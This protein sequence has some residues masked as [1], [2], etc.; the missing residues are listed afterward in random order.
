MIKKVLT[1]VFSLVVIA[2]L[3]VL[4][5]CSSSTSS[6]EQILRTNIA[7]EPAQIDPNRA[8]WSTE[9]TVIMQVFEG[10]LGFNQ[11]LSLRAIGATEIPTVANKGISADGLT[12]TFKLNSKVTWSDGK[13]VTPRTTNTASSAS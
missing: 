5:A 2:A 3:V 12:Y 6:K 11:D 7:G 1:L 10:L 9:R 13:K 8:S 4:P